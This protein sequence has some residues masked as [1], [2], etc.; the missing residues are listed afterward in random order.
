M[1]GACDA[2]VLPT[3]ELECFGLIALEALACGRPVL[4]TPVAAI[5]EV[6]S[7]FE[8]AWLASSAEEGAIADLLHAYLS[9]RL[10]V[11]SPAALRSRTQELYAQNIR[12]RQFATAVLGS[13]GEGLPPLG[14]AG[15][16]SLSR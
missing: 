12:L 3:A 9:G 7:N 5:P 2:F 16:L 8:K 11:H 14:S 13:L 1:Y 4:A 15:V 10:P 6:V